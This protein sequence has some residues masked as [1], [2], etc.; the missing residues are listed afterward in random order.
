VREL[1]ALGG[2]LL[3]LGGAYPLAQSVRP[4]VEKAPVGLSQTQTIAL[5]EKAQASL[6]GQFRGSMSDFL[7]LQVDKFVHSGIDLRGMTEKEKKKGAAAVTSGDG[8]EKGVRQ[9]GGTET[10]V[11]PDKKT[12]WRGVLGDMD[13]QIKPYKAMDGHSHQDPKNSL[14][15]YRLMT[16][17][18]PKFIRGWTE[19]AWIMSTK[20]E[21]GP[22]KALAYLREGE[23]ANPE[24]MEIASSIGWLLT[25]NL[26]RYD[27]ALVPLEKAVALGKTRDPESL[28][29]DEQDALVSAYRFL[30]NNRRYAEDIPG[31]QRWALEGLKRF[32]QDPSCRKFLEE[33]PV[34]GKE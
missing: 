32:P 16:W 14:Q 11:I 29:E 31:G 23:K 26:E 9:H 33:Y 17:S 6:F 25:R 4:V 30:V 21:L 27:E 15:L 28:T 10:T 34:R 22:E 12:D 8:V 24:S 7:Y 18:N 19:G 2:C 3:L 5:E 13:R 20:K 1:L